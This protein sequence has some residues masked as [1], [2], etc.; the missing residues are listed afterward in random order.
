M[1]EINVTFKDK[2]IL[3]VIIGGDKIEKI[4]FTYNELLE[5]LCRNRK[6]GDIKEDEPLYKQH[7]ALLALK[8]ELFDESDSPGEPDR[9]EKEE[10]KQQKQNPTHQLIKKI[11]WRLSII[12]KGQYP[13]GGEVD[14][15]TEFERIAKNID[16]YSK[17][18]TADN[19]EGAD[20]KTQ[21]SLTKGYKQFEEWE[22]KN[23][24]KTKGIAQKDRKML[25]EFIDK[26]APD[27]SMSPKDTK[28]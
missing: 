1:K 3:N 27:F 14:S 4:A 15:K 2:I 9:E 26:V 11:N 16:K 28:K 12:I 24:N 21:Y 19:K 5:E 25:E 8:K 23:P 17:T 10:S 13:K 6:I 18:N 20:K 22:K 7:L